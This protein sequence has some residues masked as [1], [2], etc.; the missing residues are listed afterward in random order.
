MTG[1]AITVTGLEDTLKALTEL[2][3]RIVKHAFAR[4]FA[5]AA[6]PMVE[7]MTVRTPVDT[8]DLKEHIQS[9]IGI[10]SDGKGGTL[11]VGFYPTSITI[12]DAGGKKHR[13]QDSTASSKARF[14]EYGHR[15]VSHATKAGLEAQAGVDSRGRKKKTKYRELLSGSGVDSVQPHPFMRPSLETSSEAAVEAFNDSLADSVNNELEG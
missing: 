11:E 5:A 9:K 14:V 13:R 4:A 3:N 2:P 12:T 8:G 7:T 10:N 6:V 1:P 15:E